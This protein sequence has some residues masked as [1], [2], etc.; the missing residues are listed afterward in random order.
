LIEFKT[1]DNKT[2]NDLSTG[3]IVVLLSADAE[4]NAVRNTFSDVQ[5][6]PYP[7]GSYFKAAIGKRDVIFARGGWGK[8]SAAASAQFT[9]DHFHPKLMVNLGTCGGFAGSMECGQII[10]VNETI[11][12]DI[13]EQM[14]DPGEAIQYYST[15]LDLSWLKRPYPQPVIPS[16]LVSADRDIVPTDIPMLKGKYQAIAADWESGSIAWVCRQNQVPCLI[17]RTVSDTVDETGGEFYDQCG[18]FAQRAG[19]IMTNLLENLPGWLD[20]C[21]KILK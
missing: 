4:W 7:Y 9:I 3:N 8:I 2:M 1:C 17:L 5:L 16:R 10:L 6:I 21:D 13:I 15:Q 14:A 11:I 18:G 20:C 12:Y 19:E